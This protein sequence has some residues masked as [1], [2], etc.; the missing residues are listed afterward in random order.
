MK[1]TMI[2]LLL[3]I[4]DSSDRHTAKSQPSQRIARV[5]ET[6]RQCPEGEYRLED[7]AKQ[8]HLSLA[9]FKGRFK[10]ELGISPW[11]FI[12]ETKIKAARPAS[13]GP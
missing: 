4:L 3:A 6:I 12:L 7:L 2:R 9:R 11:Q 8:T 5:I 10:A 1:A 13:R